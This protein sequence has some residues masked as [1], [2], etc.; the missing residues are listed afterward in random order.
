M[1]AATVIHDDEFTWDDLK[2]AYGR[3][4]DAAVRTDL[5]DVAI[6]GGVVSKI[7]TYLHFAKR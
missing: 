3:G 2:R 4:G 7:I 1:R 5:Q 6:N